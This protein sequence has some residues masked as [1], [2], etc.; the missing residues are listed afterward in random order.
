MLEDSLFY[1]CFIIRS[2]QNAFVL[3]CIGTRTVGINSAV[4]VK[5]GKDQPIHY[6]LIEKNINLQFVRHLKKTENLCMFQDD[7]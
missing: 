4:R 7:F 3:N 6:T 2:R 1:I 5:Q